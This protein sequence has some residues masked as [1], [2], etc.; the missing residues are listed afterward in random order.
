ML[1]KPIIKSCIAAAVLLSISLNTK[2]QMDH[3]LM[4]IHQDRM[5]RRQ[6]ADLS[7]AN[8]GAYKRM[9]ELSNRMEMYAGIN[10]TS[11]FV[12]GKYNSP[13]GSSSTIQKFTKQIP[14][15]TS[16]TFATGVFLPM[17]KYGEKSSLGITLNM[18]VMLLK[19]GDKLKIPLNVADT[20]RKFEVM[21]TG[22]PISVDFK[23]GCDARFDRAYP[24]MYGIGIGLN[25]M[26][27]EVQSDMNRFNGARFK[28]APFIKAEVGCYFGVAVKLR[29]MYTF[30]NRFNYYE[31]TTPEK[32]IYTN[33]S[34]GAPLDYKGTIITDGFLTV[35]L[36]INP[37][38]AMW[39]KY[40]D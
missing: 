29:V 27:Y 25:P 9:A 15:S 26:Y 5:A 32:F 19:N 10:F 3:G 22:I 13:D 28:V 30:L 36:S 1:I 11:L 7:I 14:M 18:N 38:A 6:M 16:Y 34:N 2:A 4:F 23:S 12:E 24:A 39:D 37:F 20:L 17:A 31:G 33:N 35:G 8:P 21:T 40:V